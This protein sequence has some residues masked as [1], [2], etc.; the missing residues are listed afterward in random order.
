MTQDATIWPTEIRLNPAKDELKVTFNNDKMFLFSAEFLRV[1]SP[2]AE[3]KGHTPKEKKTVGGKRNVVISTINATGNYAIRPIFSDG[4][5][6]GLFS[7]PYLYEI[8]T[9]NDQL[10]Q[11]YLAELER[12][13]LSRDS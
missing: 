9:N 5:D 7:W 10:W 12:L 3:V 6:T 4:H 13:G 11:Q 2:S 1:H 8:G